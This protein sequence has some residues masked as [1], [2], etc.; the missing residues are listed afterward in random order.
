MGRSFV[1][2]AARS[3]LVHL[4]L[5]LGLQ[6][7]V[8]AQSRSID[9]PEVLRQLSERLAD[10]L[11]K[12]GTLSTRR[13]GENDLRVTGTAR[14]RF[15]GDPPAPAPRKPAAPRVDPLEAL[16][17]AAALNAHRAS[18]AA[19]LP[20]LATER[21]AYAGAGGPQAWTD[22][23]PGF[24]RCGA[25]LRQSPVALESALAVNLPAFDIRY[26]PGPFEVDDDGRSLVVRVGGS[27]TVALGR[28]R[29]RLQEIRFHRPGEHA[30]DGRRAD[31][32]AHLL[33]S[34]PTGATVVVAVDLAL[35]EQPNPGL[36]AVLDALPLEPGGEARGIV[37]FDPA[38][39]LP[40]SRGYYHYLGSLT[41]PPCTEDVTWIV[42]RDT[43]SIA[44]DQLAL[45]AH[46]F[47]QESARPLQALN[48][49]RIKVS[50]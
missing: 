37:P 46:L 16:I 38:T 11:E 47:P 36:Q 42:L 44:A 10:T 6:A 21:W 22:L 28:D 30:I 1:I 45:Y 13:A 7:P 25:G 40:Q 48:G 2:A 8:S 43:V 17:G 27:S 15:K 3:V 33:H 5:A 39:L 49:R 20:P 19:A 34:N 23:Q 26:R 14:L 50:R 29:W 4:S 41:V 32:S 12:T 24:E 9:D 18:A 35:G 31:M